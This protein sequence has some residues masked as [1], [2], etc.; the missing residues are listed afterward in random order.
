MLSL[1]LFAGSFLLD[2]IDL[3]REKLAV[4]LLAV[5]GTL[6]SMAAVAAPCTLCCPLLG[7]PRAVDRVPVLR[8]PDLSHRPRRRSRNAP[9]RRRRPLHPRPACRRVPLQRRHRRR[10][11]SGRARCLPRRGRLRCG[12]SVSGFCLSPAAGMALGVLLARGDLRTDAP[13]SRLPGRYPAHPG[14]RAWWLCRGRQLDISGP[15]EAV[16]A[17]LALRYFNRGRI[18]GEIAHESVDRFWT[19]IDEVQNSI[20]FVL[21]GFEV[22]AIRFPSRAFVSGGAGHRHRHR[23]PLARVGLVVR[24]LRLIQPGHQSSVLTL[25]WGGLRG[26]LSIALA[27][28]VPGL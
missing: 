6:F 8:R 5:L 9:P 18:H 1:L 22:L 26:G 15:L 11:L 27:L 2:L 17:G 23:G 4:T 3:A 24:L 13:R 19:V 28:A 25:G 16:T 20:L 7:H 14:T 12:R 10:A 21:L